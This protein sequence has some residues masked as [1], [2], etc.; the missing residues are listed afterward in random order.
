VGFTGRAAQQ[1]D[2]FLEEVV[3]PALAGAEAAEIAAPRI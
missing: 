2:E 1:V 3:A